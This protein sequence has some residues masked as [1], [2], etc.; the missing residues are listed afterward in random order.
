MKSTILVITAISTAS[1]S[2]FAQTKDDSTNSIRLDASDSIVS[3]DTTV[4]VS[5]RS[6]GIPLWKHS[7]YPIKRIKFKI[8]KHDCT[9]LTECKSSEMI[10]VSEFHI[11]PSVDVHLAFVRYCLEVKAAV[12]ILYLSITTNEGKSFQETYTYANH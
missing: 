4:M 3:D 7:P 8:D 10:E 9:G 6:K 12:T 2:A 1:L 5:I 11:V